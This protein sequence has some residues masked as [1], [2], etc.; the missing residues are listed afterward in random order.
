MSGG[1]PA[2]LS[3]RAG[4]LRFA[5]SAT[6]ASAL[7]WMFG[8]SDARFGIARSCSNSARISR[9]CCARQARTSARVVDAVRS[10]RSSS[11]RIG[12]HSTGAK[13]ALEAPPA[14]GHLA[15]RALVT[16]QHD[17]VQDDEEEDGRADLDAEAVLLERDAEEGAEADEDRS[18]DDGCDEEVRREADEAHPQRAGGGIRGHAHAGKEARGENGG[19]A[20]ELEPVHSFADL[21]FPT[22]AEAVEELRA[23]EAADAVVQEVARVDADDAGERSRKKRVAPAGDQQAGGDAGDVLADEGAESEGDELEHAGL[24][25]ET[26]A[27]AGYFLRRSRSGVAMAVV[28]SAI[29]RAMVKSSAR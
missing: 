4:R 28:T 13:A 14:D 7:R 19:R 10:E 20:V 25:L 3:N 5:K 18:P 21:F 8:V 17:A 24:A 9:S 16:E 27:F 6:I 26:T 1:A 2:T 15:A 22:L 29:S 11:A 23:D 12:A